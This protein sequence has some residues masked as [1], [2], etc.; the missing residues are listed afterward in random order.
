M[1]EKLV[2]T[3][4]IVTDIHDEYHIEWCGKI[5]NTKP[6]F[7]NNKPVFVIIGS[8]GRMEV[9]TTDMARLEKCAKLMTNPKGRASVTT[10]VSKIFIKEENGNE[11]LLGILTHNNVK[12]YA[13]MYDK[14]GWK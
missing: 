8:K 1:E 4:L 2:K 12:T 3:H 11:K 10:D 7:K 13:Q 5:A 6:Y 9:N 14:V